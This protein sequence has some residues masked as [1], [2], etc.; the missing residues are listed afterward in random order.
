MDFSKRDLRGC[1]SLLVFYFRHFRS[2]RPSAVRHRR[3]MIAHAA[4]AAGARA[5]DALPLD[6]LQRI[7]RLVEQPSVSR[8]T[9]LG[10]QIPQ[11]PLDRRRPSATGDRRRAGASRWAGTKSGDYISGTETAV[12][13]RSRRVATHTTVR[14]TARRQEPGTADRGAS[15]ARS[16]TS[17]RRVEP[18]AERRR[19]ACRWRESRPGELRRHRG[20]QPSS[21]GII[22]RS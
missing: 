4:A 10:F 11:Q 18:S 13:G 16:Q 2:S 22:R 21:D 1:I 19:R 15:S 6:R 8:L 17:F 3:L 9:L 5:S 20:Q 12:L 14:G 7:P